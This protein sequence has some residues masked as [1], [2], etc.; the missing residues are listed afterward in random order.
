MC[1]VWKQYNDTQYEVS[2]TGRVR[3]NN[4]L[5]HGQTKELKCQLSEKGYKICYLTIGGKTLTK[6]VHRLVAETFLP[7]EE[8]KDEVNHINGDKQDNRIENLEWCTRIENM[9]HARRTGL[10]SGVDDY[11]KSVSK[12]IYSVDIDN[13][14]KHYYNSIEEA[15]RMLGIRRSNIYNVLHGI[16]KKT[17]RM[18]F[19][20]AVNE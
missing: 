6:R 3:S 17:H 8:G 12:R 19:R 7:R 20:F 11:V 13:G 10:M 4:Y 9:R 14:E 16:Y 5:G 18:I 2:S 15:S 1:E